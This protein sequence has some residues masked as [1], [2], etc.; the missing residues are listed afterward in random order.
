MMSCAM[1]MVPEHIFRLA[2]RKLSHLKP[3]SS[4]HGHLW[5]LWD[6]LHCWRRLLVGS[7]RR[8]LENTASLEDDLEASAL[9]W[10]LATVMDNDVKLRRYVEGVH[11]LL[12]SSKKEQAAS[13]V[14]QLRK[15]DGFPSRLASILGDIAI[16]IRALDNSLSSME[17]V[18]LH[19]GRRKILSLEVRTRIDFVL[20]GR[21]MTRNSRFQVS[22]GIGRDLRHC[23][24]RRLKNQVEFFY[25]YIEVQI[26]LEPR[27]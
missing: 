14:S 3:L 8:K 22:M 4:L 24:N 12:E 1:R 2:H 10:T 27:E 26:Q 13:I 16:S 21:L 17:A 18:S 23:R 9:A 19:F 11:I 25:H 6:R 20:A 15:A 5:R 7:T